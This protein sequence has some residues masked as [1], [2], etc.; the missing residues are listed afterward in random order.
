MQKKRGQITVFIVIGLILL[1]SV[2]LFF[3]ARYWQSRVEVAAPEDIQPVVDYIQQCLDYTA[4]DGITL[5]GIQGGYI[6]VPEEISQNPFNHLPL[7]EGFQIPYWYYNGQNKIPS[8]Q[9][10]EKEISGYIDENIESCFNFPALE[11]Y[12][13]T[14][15]GS[16]LSEVSINEEDVTVVMNFPVT[17][18]RNARSYDWN[19]YKVGLDVKFKEVYDTAIDIL[20]YEN[21]ATFLENMTIDLMSLDQDNVPI[22]GMRFDSCRRL[23]WTI[24][25]ITAHLKD[26][27]EANVPRLRVDKTDYRAFNPEDD[28]Q[29]L[30]FLVPAVT[31]RN[32]DISVG[33]RYDPSWLMFLKVRPVEG[34]TLKANSGKGFYKYLSFLCINLYHFT[35]DI[36]YPVEIMVREGSSFNGQ[37]FVLRFATP[38]LINHNLPDRTDL[39]ETSVTIPTQ[40]ADFCEVKGDKEYIIRA[41]DEFLNDYAFLNISYECVAYRCDLGRT[42]FDNQGFGPEIKTRLPEGCSSFDLVIEQQYDEVERRGYFESVQRFDYDQLGDILELKPKPYKPVEIF[43]KKHNINDIDTALDLENGD[44]VYIQIENAT[45]EY[46]VSKLWRRDGDNEKLELPLVE[47][48]LYKVD[49]LLTNDDQYLGGYTD[50]WRLGYDMNI[51]GVQEVVFHVL[52]DKTASQSD[53]KL[54]ELFD[55]IEQ[56]IFN[57]KLK[58]ELR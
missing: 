28:Y 14:P 4:R 57:A 22:T 40:P 16:P 46:F 25:E 26:V 38:V 23:T 13:I 53:E 12:V 31:A 1:L 50:T 49:I 11:G 48:G 43:V 39:S 15:Q 3:V 24:P 32:N 20:E 29:K 33:F 35:Y 30:H 45:H 8:L 9:T 21:T 27:L 52:E 10:I 54:V 44:E 5:A 17:I 34:Q 19:D 36:R 56:G 7:I 6:T 37:G 18:I 42:G 47:E 55:R 51:A 58:P 41:F 2:S